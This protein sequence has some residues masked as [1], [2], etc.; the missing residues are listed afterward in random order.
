[1]HAA[2]ARRPRAE[3]GGRA[4]GA[5]R[6]SAAQR[7][8]SSPNPD[9]TSNTPV[10]PMRGPRKRRSPSQ[11]TGFLASKPWI[12]K[13]FWWLGRN[14]TTDTQIWH[15]RATQ[16]QVAATAATLREASDRDPLWAI[17]TPLFD[18][19]R[20]AA[21]AEYTNLLRE[22]G[23]SLRAIGD[24]LDVSKSAI[25]AILKGRQV[26]LAHESKRLAPCAEALRALA[27]D[28]AA[29]PMTQ[30]LSC[31]PFPKSTPAGRESDRRGD[32]TL[33]SRATRDWTAYASDEWDTPDTPG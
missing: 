6:V 2:A 19:I 12:Y 25:S 26:R 10:T 31:W 8:S 28:P 32:A 7:R 23:L 20:V 3:V 5:R 11:W 1:M 15:P 22:R 17:T 27:T 24:R 9:R 33:H 13:D 14:R 18:P 21:R 4:A 30:P 16:S 29:E